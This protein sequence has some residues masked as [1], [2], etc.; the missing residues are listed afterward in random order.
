MSFKVVAEC[1]DIRN[2]KRFQPGEIF[3]PPPDVDQARRL[4][5]AGCIT[6][7]SEADERAKAKVEAEA[8]AKAEAEA[9]AKAKAEAEA[10]AKADAEAQ[11]KA[12]A[13]AKGRK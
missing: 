7:T 12:E 6:K 13:E 5:A 9:E 1:I 3:T 4:Q 11:A 8:K 2:G 10:Q